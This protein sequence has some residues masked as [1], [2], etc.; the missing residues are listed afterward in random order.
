MAM[1]VLSPTL[2]DPELFLFGA[3]L[4][5]WQRLWSQEPSTT[6]QS[7]TLVCAT[8]LPRSYTGPAAAMRTFMFRMEWTPA[9]DG[10][11]KGP[12][13][14][15]IDLRA[16][17]SKEIVRQIRTAWMGRVQSA[18]QDRNGLLQ[19][20]E[21]HPTETCRILKQAPRGAQSF[22]AR[23]IIGGFLSLAS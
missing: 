16:S 9:P 18:L 17:S 22:L 3:M 19:V 13:N 12:G 20:K 6:A 2:Q 14:T 7:W 10:T 8:D 11:L 21:P 1:A 15:F 4:R 23:E 5:L